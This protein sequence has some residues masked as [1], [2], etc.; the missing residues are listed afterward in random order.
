MFDR[1]YSVSISNASFFRLLFIDLR[2][3]RTKVIVHLPFVG[4][5]RIACFKFIPTVTPLNLFLLECLDTASFL[6][7]VYP[8]ATNKTQRLGQKGIV[9]SVKSEF[10]MHSNEKSCNCSFG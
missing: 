6:V 5:S 8:F 3:P 9:D 7:T 1:S 4:T 2:I 10:I